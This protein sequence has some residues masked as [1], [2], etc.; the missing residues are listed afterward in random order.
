M[1]TKTKVI[2]TVISLAVAFAFGRYTT[3]VKT[4]E[5]IKTVEVDKK[6]DDKK[7]DRQKDDNSVTTIVEVTHPDGTKE[8][9]TTITHKTQDHTK[10]DESRREEDSKSSETT[11]ETYRSSGRVTISALGGLY[12]P[13]FPS[14]LAS[15]QRVYGIA[16]SKEVL[17][18]LSIGVFGLND[19]TAGI[20]VGLSF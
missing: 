4:V 5:V 15:P 9:T 18:P 20:S 17:G 8:K 2:I 14:S 16:V 3:P 7:T 19:Y 11:K 12:L 1:T 6:T 10:T 13:N